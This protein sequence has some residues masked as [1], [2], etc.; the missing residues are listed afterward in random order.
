MA[1]QTGNRD[2][3][4][5]LYISPRTAEK[6]IASL[7]AKIG[8]PDRAALHRYSRDTVLTWHAD[9]ADGDGPSLHTQTALSTPDADPGHGP[10]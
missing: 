6:H 8:Q 9:R 3:A 5:R 10:G 2:I 7:I 1:S 4:S